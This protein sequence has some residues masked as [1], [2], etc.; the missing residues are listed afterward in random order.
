VGNTRSNP[1]LSG[2]E[3][4]P[5]PANNDDLLEIAQTLPPVPEADLSIT[6]V[7]TT[8]EVEPGDTVTFE[9]ELSNLGPDPATGYSCT[10]F[11]FRALP[12]PVISPARAAMTRPPASGPSATWPTAGSE[13]QAN[14][15]LDAV[16]NDEG[17]YMH[18][19]QAHRE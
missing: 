3:F 17:P 2:N 7:A 13:S 4:D 15:K 11:S 18:L 16:V 10:P 8:G 14:F 1:R 19:V 6:M 5:W 9:V 12:M